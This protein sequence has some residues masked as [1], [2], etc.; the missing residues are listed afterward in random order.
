[1]NKNNITIPFTWLKLFSLINTLKRSEII[2]N[3]SIL[4]S[5]TALAQLIPI[6]LQPFLR[7]FFTPEVFG[8]YSVFL[9]LVGILAIV[10]SFKYE[11]AIVLPSRDKESVNIVFL[12]FL[13]NLLFS[14]ILLILVLLFKNRILQFFNLS[15][16]FGFYLYLVPASIFFYNIY[17]NLNNWLVRKKKF[18]AISVNKLVRRGTEGFFQVIFTFFKQSWGLVAGDLLGHVGNLLSGLYQ[19]GKSGLRFSLVSPAKLKYVALKYSEFPRF[20]VIPSFMSACSFLLPAIF[21]NKFFAAENTGFFDLSKL[22]LSVPLALIS[23]SL[24]N[25]L[26]QSMSEKF[27]MNESMTRDITHVLF[28]VLVICAG[29]IIVIQLFGI[30]IFKILF[31]HEWAYSGE[32]SKILV[33]SYSLNFIVGSFS[34]VLI[35]FKKIRLLSFWQFFYFISILSL[36]FFN[37]LSFIDFI[38]VYVFIE[39]VCYIV[40]IIMIISVVS[41]YEQK[42]VMLHK[43]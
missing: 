13:I 25:V 21:I 11:L 38:R 34:A 2:R 8:A 26:L 6:L 43:Q 10:A 3:T 24:S 17:Q 15:E 41:R 22:L 32:I 30:L 9:S 42:L 7:R 33:W 19:S 23:T 35:S 40:M 29:E 4:V 36:T 12:A 5:G 37:K 28:V 16:D 18:A 1:M 39:V 20:N 31:G 27:R 14:L